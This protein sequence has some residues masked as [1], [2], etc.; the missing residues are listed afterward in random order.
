MAYI[1][2]QINKTTL[3]HIINTRKITREYIASKTKIKIEKIDKWLDVSDGT[4]PTL[5]QAKEMATCLHVPFAALYM[6]PQDIPVKEI[7]KIKNMRTLYN[8]RCMDDSSLNIAIIDLLMA[9]DFLCDIRSEL[10]FYAP[11]FCAPTIAGASVI[12]WANEIRNF[13]DIRLDMQFKCTSLRKFYLYLRGQLEKAWIFIHCFTDVPIEVIRGV[14]IYDSKLPIIGVNGNDRPPAK[15]F[16]IIHELVHLLKRES[17]LCNEMLN[18]F[19]VQQEE[20]FCNAVAGEVLVPK[21]ALESVLNNDLCEYPYS[22][23]D[24]A[25]VASK[26]SVSREV[27][28]RRLLDIGRIE[29]NEYYA[30][31]DEISVELERDKEEQ[32]IAR[33][34]G[35][36]KKAMQMPSQIAIDRTSQSI[37]VA[38]FQGYCESIYSKRDIANH[39]GINQKHV[40]R[41]LMEVAKW[42]S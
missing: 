14:A 35:R 33:R 24:I 34:E 32:R 5:N 21:Y 26:F 38:L 10:G 22:L 3:L 36:G 27:I 13:F 42:N 9:R 37:C 17:S 28:L 11:E 2:A 39:V 18:S 20:V 31:V 40:D 29:K 30:Y 19:A 23:D 7:P 6:N 8:E 4:F 16:T 12:E 41:F 15:S 1:Y 25:K